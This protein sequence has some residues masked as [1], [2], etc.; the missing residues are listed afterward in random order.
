MKKVVILVIILKFQISFA[1]TDSLNLNFEEWISSSLE[2]DNNLS[3]THVIENAFIGMPKKWTAIKYAVHR[4][5]D[6]HEGNFAIV[7]HIYY[8]LAKEKLK[9]SINSNKM[10]T[11]L[12]GYYKYYP[13]KDHLFPNDT[14]FAIGEV[15]ITETI[16]NKIDT[17][18]I[19]KIFFNPSDTY[20]KF[21]IKPNYSKKT[22]G[23]INIFLSFYTTCTD[24]CPN[25]SDCIFLYLDALKLNFEFTKSSETSIANTCMDAETSCNLYDLTGRLILRNVRY[26]DLETHNLSIGMYFITPSK[27]N[28]CPT[29]AQKYFRTK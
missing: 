16:N 5:T 10:I 20:K 7:S 4:T 19:N 13:T 26:K 27:N 28:Y 12:E 18:G 23:N 6:A 14:P 1:Q 2:K 17:I 25:Y 3:S 15:L 21:D 9:L 11:S 8:G 29:Y 24:Y 22:S